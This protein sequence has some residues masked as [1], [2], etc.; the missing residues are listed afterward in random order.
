MTEAERNAM[1]SNKMMRTENQLE[2]MERIANILERIE[3]HLIN[4]SCKCHCCSDTNK[5]DT[6]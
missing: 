2:L 3:E 5:E 6:K 4:N 1:R